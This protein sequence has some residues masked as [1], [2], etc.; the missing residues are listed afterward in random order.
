MERSP[1]L[2][3]GGRSWGSSLGRARWRPGTLGRVDLDW[4]ETFLAVVE[5]G[6]FTAAS[7]EIHR[8]QS[9]VSAHIASLERQ[10]G[11]R[12]LDR[13]RRPVAPT[14]AGEVFAR[15]ARDIVAGVGTARTAIAALR[16]LDQ[17]SLTLITT[18]CVGAALFPRVLARVTAERP[19]L[20]VELAERSWHD[21]ERRFVA[22]GAAL[23][24]LPQLDEPAAAGLR[25]RVLWRECLH[26]VVRDDH[27][28]ALG[29]SLVTV[30]RLLR[31]PLLVC[32]ASGDGESE[33]VRLL[34]RRGVIAQPRVT[35][36]TPQTLVSLARAGVGVAVVNSVA[37]APLDLTG[38]TVLELDDPEPQRAVAAYWNDVLL[39]TDAGRRLHRAVLEAPVPNGAEPVAD[40]DQA[41]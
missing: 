4:L 20:R 33:F 24:V 16:G 37:L 29:G 9:R 19:G 5:R 10:L 39:D 18:A 31:T 38:L 25:Q 22:D 11:V 14:P 28:L 1:F 26:V 35:A 23:A 41:G 12:L 40:V 36:D 3:F 6:G 27:E 30:D 2:G 32:R 8:S 17:R 7:E 15:H 13:T 34:A 21:V